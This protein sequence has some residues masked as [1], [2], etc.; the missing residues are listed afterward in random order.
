MALVNGNLLKGIIMRVIGSTI[1]SMDKAYLN[2]T[3]ALI[4]ANSK[5]SLSMDM[6]NRFLQMAINTQ[7]ST[8]KASPREEEGMTGMQEAIIKDS[9]SQ[10]KE[11]D[12]GYGMTQTGQ[13]MK[14]NSKKIVNME[15]ED[16]C[17]SQVND[18]KAYS[19]RA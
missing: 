14:E 15:K 17:T 6:A 2:I 13:S 11:M 16:R 19:V 10:E 7:V 1:G 18:F 8:N 5:I 3:L 12:M 4:K 9:L